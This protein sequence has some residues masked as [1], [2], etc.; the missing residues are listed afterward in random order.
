MNN[1]NSGIS[2]GFETWHRTKEIKVF[3]PSQFKKY[4][5]IKKAK[6]GN[7]DMTG[8]EKFYTGLILTVAAA[9][10]AAIW[11]VLSASNN[12]PHYPY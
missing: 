11:I 9:F 5:E 12:I 4:S 7:F 10:L 6:V 1:Y 2:L 3:T 8:K